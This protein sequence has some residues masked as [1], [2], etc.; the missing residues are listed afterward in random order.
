MALL[1]IL[2]TTRLLGIPVQDKR[3]LLEPKRGWSR[4][5]LPCQVDRLLGVPGSLLMA[6]TISFAGAV[7]WKGPASRQIPK[8]HVFLHADA[9]C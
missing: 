9:G 7:S 3:R 1:R 2:N 6:L 8:N 4:V 5:T